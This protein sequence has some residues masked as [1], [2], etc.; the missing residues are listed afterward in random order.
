MT[1]TDHGTDHKK[2]L[3]LYLQDA[4]DAFLWKL[5]GLGEYDIRRPMTPPAPICWGWSSM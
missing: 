5:E 4:R 3:L 2:D 1:G